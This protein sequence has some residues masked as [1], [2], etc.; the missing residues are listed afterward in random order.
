MALSLEKCNGLNKGLADP[1]DVP[2]YKSG[3]PIGP[4]VHHVY[5]PTWEVPVEVSEVD[6]S[7]LLHT[8]PTLLSLIDFVDLDVCTV[9]NLSA[10]PDPKYLPDHPGH[11]LLSEHTPL[12]FP[13]L[14]DRSK[15]LEQT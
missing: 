1:P 7:H 2:S 9:A 8:S 10:P 12:E 15:P 14:E 11:L 5:I 4:S 6:E 3:P 13:D